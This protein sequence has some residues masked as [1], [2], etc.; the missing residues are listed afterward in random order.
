MPFASVPLRQPARAF[1]FVNAAVIFPTLE[2]IKAPAHHSCRTLS[3]WN[4]ITTL[5]RSA[6]T[7]E[8]SAETTGSTMIR[9][10]PPR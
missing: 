1:G 6:E 2:P 10:N 4:P 3:F 7:L 8:Q 5:E 9:E